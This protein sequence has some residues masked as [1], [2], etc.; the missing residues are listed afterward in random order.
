M[1]IQLYST[2]DWKNENMKEGVQKVMMVMTFYLSIA[3]P[4]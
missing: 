4:N 3:S 2:E 1:A